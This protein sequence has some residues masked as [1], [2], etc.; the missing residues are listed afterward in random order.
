M[1]KEKKIGKW[2][3]VLNVAAILVGAGVL[4][5]DMIRPDL[6]LK[7]EVYTL[8]YGN[9]LPREVTAY[10]AFFSEEDEK[11]AV[12]DLGGVTPEYRGTYQAGIILNNK[13]HSFTID[14]VDTI[15]PEYVLKEESITADLGETL[16]ASW[17]FEEIKDASYVSKAFVDAEGNTDKKYLCS[18]VGESELTVRVADEAGN[19]TDVVL[20]LTVIEPDTT[21]PVISGVKDIAV[22]IGNTPDYLEGVTAEDETDGDLTDKIVVD[23]SKV[24]V[25]KKGA[26]PVTYTCKDSS[27]NEAEESI[28]LDVKRKETQTAAK[29]TVTETAQTTQSGSGQ[30]ASKIEAPKTEETKKEESK[31]ASQP[32]TPKQETPKKEENKQEAPK[33]EVPKQEEP[34]KE[35]TKPAPQPEE[36]E[37]PDHFD[38]DVP[39]PETEE[40]IRREQEEFDDMIS[41]SDNWAN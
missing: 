12:L 25:N 4:I 1:L 29:T 10:A 20:K 8:E 41:D 39:L 7:H 34:K 31:P 28:F 40:E 33:A 17:L 37:A 9:E 5:K 30:S 26:Y 32:E 19:A 16:Y 21:A 6:M 23:T 11:E 22:Y 13:W 38:I 35:E 24:N 27:G 14:V 36:N 2:L 15:A 3:V 18:E